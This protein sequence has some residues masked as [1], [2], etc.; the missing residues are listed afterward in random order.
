MAVSV[1]LVL[2]CLTYLVV[3]GALCLRLPSLR[4]SSTKAPYALLLGLGLI[5]HLVSYTLIIVNFF[6]LAFLPRRRRI[7]LL[8][9]ICASL[10]RLTPL[11]LLGC[12]LLALH[13]RLGS[14]TAAQPENKRSRFRISR[15]L[16]WLLFACLFIVWVLLS[17]QS[18]TVSDA[19]NGHRAETKYPLLTELGE[20][21]HAAIFTC[22]TYSILQLSRSMNGY[23]L[24]P[25]QVCLPI[26]PP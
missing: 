15:Y 20:L 3:T 10:L 9:I 5:I 12:I 25:D 7:H 4:P 11:V 1:I 18:R 23:L 19:L 22:M 16:H 26:H 17:V 6:L 24:L 14:L 8:S 2:A 13:S 21:L